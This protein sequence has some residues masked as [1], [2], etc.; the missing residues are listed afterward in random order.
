MD[1]PHAGIKGQT[2]VNH[3][4]GVA[5]SHTI[6][7]LRLSHIVN[8]SSNSSE[9]KPS[10]QRCSRTISLGR[11]PHPYPNEFLPSGQRAAEGN[12]QHLPPV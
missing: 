7:Q 9:S 10:A 5:T 6:N 4:G 1:S 2:P 8:R 11:E 3:Q 12:H